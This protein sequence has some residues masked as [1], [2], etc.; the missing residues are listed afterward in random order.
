VTS[1]PHCTSL[2]AAILADEL[3]HLGPQALHLPIAIERMRLP[4]LRVLLV[5]GR[6][7][8]PDC[9]LFLPVDQ[10]GHVGVRL[11]GEVLIGQ[12]VVVHLDGAGMLEVGVFCCIE[13]GR[14][15]R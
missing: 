15:V 10:F 14:L 9:G 3:L 11:G 13:R 1:A 8:V 12:A 4:H 2:E 5:H 7:V 6:L